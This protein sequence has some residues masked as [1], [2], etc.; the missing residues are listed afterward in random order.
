MK[1]NP[2]RIVALGIFLGAVL[3]YFAFYPARREKRLD[4][5]KGKD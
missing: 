4:G 1:M 3:T 2:Y 5:Q